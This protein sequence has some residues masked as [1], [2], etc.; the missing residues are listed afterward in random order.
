MAGQSGDE[1][2]RVVSTVNGP[3]VGIDIMKG[4]PN[5]SR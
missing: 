4:E 1:K 3:A 5:E 2:E